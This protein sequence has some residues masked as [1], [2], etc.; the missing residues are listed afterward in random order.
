M[1]L[2]NKGFT[3]VELLASFILTMII[4]V[5]LF[6]IVLELRNVYINETVRTD[7]KNKNAIV[8][9]TINKMLDDEAI[10]NANC[11]GSS[12]TITIA[13]DPTHPKTI[14]VSGNTV[15]IN[16]QKIV[17]SDKVKLE[18]INLTKIGPNTTDI[19]SDNTIIKIGYKIKS[20]DLN[21][22]IDF[23]LIYTYLS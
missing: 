3:V 14:S 13:S 11:T 21:K 8:S 16:K 15:T 20:A 19:T 6:E 17:Y 4:V 23:N 9:N 10:T 12:C 5:F 22:D 1:K 7:T 18:N 2:N